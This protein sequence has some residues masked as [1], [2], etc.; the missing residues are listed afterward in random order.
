VPESVLK[1]RK[2][3]EKYAEAAKAAAAETTK[4][5]AASKEEAFKRA[6][7][8]IKQYR[9][10][11]QSLVTLKRAARKEGTFYVPEEP[12]LIF[13]MRLRGIMGM[14]PKT[15]H[16]MKVLR[17]LQMHNGVFMRVNK[18]TMN[19]L[20]KVDPYIMYGY[21]NLKTVRDLIYKRGYAKVNGQRVPL[22]DNKIIEDGLAAKTKG[23]VICMED[24]VNQIYTVGPYFK[25]CT[26]FLWP[27]KMNNPAGG[28]SRI[29]HH[30]TEGGDCG[31]REEYVNDVSRARLAIELSLR[32]H[33]LPQS[34]D[35]LHARSSHPSPVRLLFAA[36]P[37][38]ALETDSQ[39]RFGTLDVMFVW[40]LA[41][42]HS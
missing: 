12:K 2:R 36:H 3:Q 8:Y 29:R 37:A 19:N 33:A 18:A 32:C 39:G 40:W 38:H 21:P 5:A 23:A 9:E 41:A 26:K 42:S 10:E 31:N 16:I 35:S 7:S 14:A 25:E 13:V 4:K 20:V 17:L 24:L 34:L 11:E 30:F 15:R 27:F 6:E 1:K 22:T 28:L